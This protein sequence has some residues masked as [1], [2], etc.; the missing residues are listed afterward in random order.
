MTALISFNSRSSRLQLEL[1][2]TITINNESIWSCWIMSKLTWYLRIFCILGRGCLWQHHRWPLCGVMT[3]TTL[4]KGGVPDREVAA[5][6]MDLTL[7]SFSFQ[8][9]MCHQKTLT[10]RGTFVFKLF[11]NSTTFSNLFEYGVEAKVSSINLVV[12]LL[13]NNFKTITLP[14]NVAKIRLDLPW[15]IYSLDL[16]SSYGT[17]L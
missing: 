9:N 5:P 15:T 12:I 2:G 14:K 4:C 1:F 10:K 6:G 16:Q 13:W 7:N 8:C 11:H 17:Y 3:R